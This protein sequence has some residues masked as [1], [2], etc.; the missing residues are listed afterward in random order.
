MKLLLISFKK[1][2][3]VFC[4]SITL[5]AFALFPSAAFSKPSEFS[6]ALDEAIQG[7]SDKY[8]LAISNGTSAESAAEVAS[9]QMITSLIF[10]GLLTEVM[11]LPKEEMA[12][13]VATKIFNVCGDEIRISEQELNDYL[14][15]L[16]DSDS[17]DTQEKPFKPFGIG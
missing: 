14:V 15:E 1:S 13:F 16:A 11:S 9:R 10:S 4:A 2:I 6:P 3:L 17:N 5:F 7:F 12:S 8:C